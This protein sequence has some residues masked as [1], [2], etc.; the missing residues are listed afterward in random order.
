MKQNFFTYSDCVILCNG[1]FPTHEIPLT[2]LKKAKTI[3]CCDG[4]TQKLLDFGKEPTV[5]VGDLD[6]ASDDILERFSDRIFHNPDQETNDLTKAAQWAVSHG[7]ESIT[8][9]G[10]TGLR[11]DHT[12]GNISLLAEYESLFDSVQM[13][14]DSGVFISI[15]QTME[16]KSFCG[17]QVS[18]FSLNPTTMVAS[19]NL[20]YPL[21]KTFQS[22]WC[23]T[24][25]ESLSNSFTIET[26]G[27]V[28]VFRNFS[29]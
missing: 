3:I 26:N 19:K 21:P 5:I 18:L 10:A 29:K 4:A 23:G 8:I 6:S 22:W 20:K 25:N 28:I 9:L 12:L 16:C 15:S 13:V 1:L 24:L 7:I 27:C 2:I 11:E 17:Q 14:T